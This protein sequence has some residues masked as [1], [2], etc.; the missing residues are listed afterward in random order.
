[1]KTHVNRKTCTKRFVVALF[2]I[3]KKQI[4]YPRENGSAS[5]AIVTQFSNKSKPS[6]TQTNVD[7]SHSHYAK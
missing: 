7:E 2:I 3:A 6:D 1:M 4:L 5:F